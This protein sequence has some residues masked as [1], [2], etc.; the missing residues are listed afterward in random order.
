MWSASRVEFSSYF[1]DD[2][3]GKRVILN[4]YVCTSLDSFVHYWTLFVGSCVQRALV[5]RDQPA[6]ALCTIVSITYNFL[7]CKIARCNPQHTLMRTDGRHSII[8]LLFDGR[9]KSNSINFMLFLLSDL[10][11]AFNRSNFPIALNY[12]LSLEALR[13][14]ERQTLSLKTFVS[15]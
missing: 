6:D 14:P 12:L 10:E 15:F 11:S 7:G 9:I 1:D 3:G 4:Y 8:S 5:S 2:E 13:F